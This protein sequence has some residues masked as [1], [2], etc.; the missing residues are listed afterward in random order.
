MAFTKVFPLHCIVQNYAWG[1]KG[2]QSEVAA[3]IKNVCPHF[4][5]EENKPYAELWMGTH[6]SGPSTVMLAD[7][8][9]GS[10]LSQ[11][12]QENPKFLGD[13]IQEKF[14]LNLPFLFKV[15][16]V[17]TALSI[18]AHPDKALA[19]QL[20]KAKPDLYKDPNHKPE[21]ALALTPFEALCGFRPFS[22]ICRFLKNI[23]EF[24]CITGETSVKSMIEAEDGDGSQQKMAL[25]KAFSSVMNQPVDKIVEQLTL[26]TNR[27]STMEKQGTCTDDLMG[28]LLLRI[29]KDFPGDV[30]CFGIY[31]LNYLQLN[32]GQATFLGAN[33]AHAYLYGDCMEIMACSDNTV[34]AGLTPKFLDVQTL[35]EMLTYISGTPESKL[36]PGTTGQDKYTTIYDPP[37]P[38]FTLAK[39]QVP[40]NVKNYTIPA[41][42]S[43]SILL[44]VHGDAQT[45]GENDT[46]TIRMSRGSVI[47]VAAYEALDV[48]IPALDGD[49]DILL[50][51]AYCQL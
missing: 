41:L 30:G 15:L 3:L 13:K 38:D 11:I 45:A 42:D 2:T 39:I 48:T 22:E 50:F 29:H 7:G 25:K 16:S 17:N 24:A 12:L 1:K 14:G 33:E 9:K 18:Q 10:L 21:M 31:F 27:I 51:R 34:R 46:R 6:P 32:P 35:C 44:M 19:E 37:I 43:A 5:I 49:Q 36:F 20:H 47:F 40:A 4:H 26:L 8:T 28:K 23:P